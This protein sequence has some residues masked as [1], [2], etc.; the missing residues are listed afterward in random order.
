MTDEIE[1]RWSQLMLRLDAPDSRLIG[2]LEEIQSA[3]QVELFGGRP[4]LGRA[5]SRDP[6]PQSLAILLDALEALELLE[7]DDASFPWDRALILKVV[8]RPLDAAHA[9]VEAA[10]RFLRGPAITGDDSDWAADAREMA[11]VCF[12]TAGRRASAAAVKALALG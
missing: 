6:E 3:L 8:G 9:Y 2:D 7:S 10:N 1:K 4:E 12:E 11:S 5:T